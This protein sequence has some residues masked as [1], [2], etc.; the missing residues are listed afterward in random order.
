MLFLINIKKLRKAIETNIRLGWLD[1]VDKKGIRITIKR[2]KKMI[3]EKNSNGDIKVKRRNVIK[4]E[5]I[6]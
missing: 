5:I 2:K 6:E 1:P 4:I 3:L